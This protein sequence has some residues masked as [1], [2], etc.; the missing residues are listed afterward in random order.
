MSFPFK[1]LRSFVFISIT[2]SQVFHP[3]SKNS[4]APW[5]VL[6]FK[7]ITPQV[8]SICSAAATHNWLGWG[9]GQGGLP[10]TELRHNMFVFLLIA[11]IF[12]LLF[13]GEQFLF[14]PVSW[15]FPLHFSSDAYHPRLMEVIQSGELIFFFF[16][17]QVFSSSQSS[18]SN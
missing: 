16:F 15:N 7:P 9:Q 3:P 11:L 1:D 4:S 17:K 2:I 12:Y 14:L 8:C 6:S 18:A 13:L 5:A 10:A